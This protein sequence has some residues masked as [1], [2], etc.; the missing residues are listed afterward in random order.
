MRTRKVAQARTE[1]AHGASAVVGRLADELAM[2]FHLPERIDESGFYLSTGGDGISELEFTT[3]TPTIP[4]IRQ[5]GDVRVRYELIPDEEADGESFT[6]IRTE[7]ADLYGNL[8]LDGIEYKMLDGITRFTVECYDGEEWV[9]SWDDSALEEPLLPLAVE[10][11][12]GWAEGEEGERT[13][14]AATPLYASKGRNSRMTGEL[15]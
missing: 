9:E 3:R 13:I 10:I 7:M 6:L 2:A 12:I 4:T 1:A 14:S 5:G 8:D 15:E 11:V